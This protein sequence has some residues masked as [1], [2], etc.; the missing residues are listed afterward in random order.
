MAAADKTI[1]KDPFELDWSGI[2][3]EFEES[4]RRIGHSFSVKTQANV[5]KCSLI[6]AVYLRDGNILITDNSNRYV[7][8]FSRAGRLKDELVS[9][10]EPYGIAM[11][12]DTTAAVTYTGVTRMQLISVEEK[13][14]VQ[15]DIELP[16]P[17]SVSVHAVHVCGYNG[18]LAVTCEEDNCLYI[19]TR[20]GNVTKTL[21]RTPPDE[22][23]SSKNLFETAGAVTC[24]Q[25]GTVLYVTDHSAQEL[26]AV[27]EKGE[28]KFRYKHP[29]LRRPAGVSVDASGNV[30]VC[31]FES[32]NVHQLTADGQHKSL[33]P[34][35]NL[36][37]WEISFEPNTDNFLLTDQ[38]DDTIHLTTLSN[39]VV[40]Y[41]PMYQEMIRERNKE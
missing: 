21:R 31:G 18:Q 39:P 6:G 41:S 1:V 19:V 8:L 3:E 16:F 9:E 27:T 12:D 14:F 13:L 24:N 5:H 22:H 2:V 30:Y 32:C 26:I 33:L 25:A 11:L 29:K 28:V 7:K 4:E 10:M 34:Q 15:S 17:P 23:G 38:Y 20:D 37:F 36:H 35:H 40:K